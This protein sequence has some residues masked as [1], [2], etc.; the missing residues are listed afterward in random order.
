MKNTVIS[1]LFL[2][3]STFQIFTPSVVLANHLQPKN[4]CDLTQPNHCVKGYSCLP[5][6][7]D[8]QRGICQ[9]DPFGENFGKIQ[10]PEALKNFIGT[11]QTGS[12]AI[13]KFLTN[14]IALIYIIATIVLIFMLLWG[15]F[16]WITSGG[17]KEKVHAARER[18]TQ[19]FIGIILFAVAFAVIA[20]VGA[21][22]GF[23]FFV[24]QP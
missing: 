3:I 19:A 14:L 10:P 24:G 20:V 18:I 22:T 2:T 11:D 23:K 7:S 1:I 5:S 13:S 4:G 16:D 21:F 6:Q 15:A 17:D 9:E 12:G 8:P